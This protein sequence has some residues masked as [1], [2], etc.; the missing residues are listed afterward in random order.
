VYV[1]TPA[2]K[3][4]LLDEYGRDLTS[5]AQENRLGPF[6]GRRNEIL[7]IIQ[8][9][10]QRYSNNPLLVGRAGVGKTSL[11]EALA[12]RMANGKD[13]EQLSQKRIVALNI[14]KI[15]GGLNQK[16]QFEE[17]LGN[18][19]EETISQPNIILFIDEIYNLLGSG[20]SETIMNVS[21]LLTPLIVQGELRIIGTISEEEFNRGLLADS[22]LERKFQ[23]IIINEPSRRDTLEMLNI[24]RQKLEE[25]HKVWITDRA[26]EA[27]IDLSVEFD[28]EHALP[29]KAIDLVDEA[30]AQ[31]HIPDLSMLEGKQAENLGVQRGGAH[32]ILNVLGIAR[33][34]SQKTGVPLDKIMNSLEPEQQS[35]TG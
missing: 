7:Q 29:A 17:R 8:T 22:S 3:V 27:A 2:A 16:S 5:E 12:L 23:K 14:S 34:L 21:H 20:H 11:V 31:I 19:L 28:P 4:S 30:G 18:I 32:T 9:L 15:M 24:F 10:A 6:A 35:S 25:F 1:Q 33:V 26:L 13:S